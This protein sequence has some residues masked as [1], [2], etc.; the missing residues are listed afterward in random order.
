[1]ETSQL[2]NEANNI[3]EIID[4][5]LN[6]NHNEE[7]TI[8]HLLEELGEVARQVTNKNIRKIARDE[9]NLEEEIADVQL[10]IMRLATINNVDIENA[11]MSK[12]KKLK[13]RHNLP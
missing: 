4:K 3:I 13:E 1:M 11:I 7:N 8:I 5:K 6:V 10:F 12:I 2:Q 9:K